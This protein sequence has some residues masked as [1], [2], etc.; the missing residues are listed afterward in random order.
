M[1]GPFAI[2]LCVLFPAMMPGQTLF[3]LSIGSDD[4]RLEQRAGEGFHLFIRKKPD[5]AS[6]LLTESTRDPSMN[7]D[8]YAYRAPEWNPFNGDEI[9]LLNGVPIPSSSRI[10]SLVSSTPEFHPELEEAFHI[11][12]PWVVSY[13]YEEGRHGEVLMTNGAY[14]NIRTFSLPYADYRGR[15]LDNP[16]MLQGI[17]KPIEEPDE[18]F[19]REI[20]EAYSEIARQGNGD[21][22]LAY[23]PPDL[24]KKMESILLLESSGSSL[25]VVICIDTTGSMGRYIDAVRKML[26]PMMKEITSGYVPDE[27]RIGMVLYRDYPP[28][29]YLTKII[30]FTNDFVRFQRSLDAVVA[31]GG[32][33]IPEAV[34]EALYEG[35]DSFLWEAEKRLLILVGDA[36]PHPQQRGK[37]SSAMVN[38]KIAENNLKVNAILLPE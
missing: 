26:I 7:A 22:I 29:L 27:W 31:W 10:F 30:P 5:I 1:A 35:A 13:G 8:N 21:F 16:F 15:F 38:Q 23:D 14:I 33:D 12:V 34:Y 19:M 28:D 6:V 18:N 2:F 4:L 17:Q 9:R 20:A 11:F 37:I 32:G 25:D 3:D 36:P 24:I